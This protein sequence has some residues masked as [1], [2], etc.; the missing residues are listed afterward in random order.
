MPA[1]V[2]K[3][4]DQKYVVIDADTGKKIKF[5]GQFKTRKAALDQARAINAAT[6]G[7]RKEK[8]KRKSR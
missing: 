7:G 6:E 1:K 5:S 2:K 4:D 8:R 3:L